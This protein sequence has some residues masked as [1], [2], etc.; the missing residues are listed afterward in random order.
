MIRA[1]LLFLTLACA[2]CDTGGYYSGG[3][4]IPY[5]GKYEIVCKLP[6][7]P[8]H[9]EWTLKYAVTNT[10]QACRDLGGV[11]LK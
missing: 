5:A 7:D 6:H 3:D 10:K 4:L 2:G 1:G 8:S 11:P 9:P